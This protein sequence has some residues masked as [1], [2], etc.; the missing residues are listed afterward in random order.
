MSDETKAVLDGL[1]LKLTSRKLM[2][3]VTA[4]GLALYGVVDSS[5]WV[6]VALVYI[7]SEAAVDIASVWRHG[8]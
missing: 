6:A 2:V 5:D 1:L 4:T 8:K 3:W 7:G